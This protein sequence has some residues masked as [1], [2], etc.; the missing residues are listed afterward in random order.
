[1][2]HPG[3]SLS[4]WQPTWSTGC[5]SDVSSTS[6]TT[7]RVR[8]SAGREPAKAPRRRSPASPSCRSCCSPRAGD[9]AGRAP[10]DGAGGKTV[11]CARCSLGSIRREC[12]SRRSA[13]PPRRSWATTS[14]GVHRHAPAAGQIGVFNRSHYEDVL[15]VRVKK[16]ASTAVWRKRCAYPA[17]RAD[18]RRR[19]HHD[20]QAV[21]ER[22]GGGA[23]SACR[24]ASTAPTSAGSS[25][26]ATWTTASCGRPTSTPTAMPWRARRCPTHRGTSSRRPQM[27]AQPDG[28][29]DPAAHDRAARP[30]VSEAGTGNRWG[31]SSPGRRHSGFV[32]FVKCPW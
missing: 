12:G 32:Q 8:R 6:T 25:A 21:L 11:C 3:P 27:G 9:R 24:I 13:C 5:A 14:S 28:G 30:A 15:V 7:I 22:V 31:S 26:W 19:G 10:G 17:V 20:R 1:M 23:T 18:A 29:P 16:L 2:P 4:S